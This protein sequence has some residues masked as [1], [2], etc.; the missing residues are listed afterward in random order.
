MFEVLGAFLQISQEKSDFLIIFRII[1][2]LEIP[3]TG[4]MG[5]APHQAPVHRGPA[6]IAIL[7]APPKLGLRLLWSSRSPGKGGGGG[8]GGGEHVC[9]LIGAREVVKRQRGGEEWPAAV[10][11]R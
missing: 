8:G 3:W 9:G 11:A 10:S 6:T 4:S 1:F 7:G 5:H 2:Q